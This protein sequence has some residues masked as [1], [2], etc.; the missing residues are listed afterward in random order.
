MAYAAPT[1]EQYQERVRAIKLFQ[2]EAKSIKGLS[3]SEAENLAQQV[4]KNLKT[5]NRDQLSK[6]MN[7]Q[8]IQEF[9][10]AAVSK[11]KTETDG[12]DALM[13]K[14]DKFQQADCA[15]QQAWMK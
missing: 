14:A 8:E 6:G 3:A 15:I 5:I 1:N 10:H 2:N 9:I 7:C 4:L 12:I 11:D 13:F